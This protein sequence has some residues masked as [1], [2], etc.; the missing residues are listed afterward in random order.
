MMYEPNVE[1]PDDLDNTQP[2]DIDDDAAA[3]RWLRARAHVV[4]E[5]ARIE[6]AKQAEIRDVT[7]WAN[8]ASHG[9]NRRLSWLD[10]SLEGYARAVGKPTHKLPGGSLQL[11][12]ARARVEVEDNV[13]GD[14]LP[15]ELQAVKISPSKTAIKEHTTP[16]P[17][18]DI[19]TTSGFDVPFGYTLHLAVTADGEVV[20]G[21][22]HVV[23]NDDTRT[24]HIA[25]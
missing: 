2:P 1:W 11:R 3:N 20:P 7:E 24:F 12:K 17:E 18:V 15:D 21:V 23:P 6:E 25:Q 4:A 8:D 9:L 10:H 14:M 16:G 5:L 22:Y 13:G 19:D